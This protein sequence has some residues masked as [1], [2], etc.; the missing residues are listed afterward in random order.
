[1]GDNLTVTINGKTYRGLRGSS[2]L[3]VA[4]ANGIDIPTLC[5]EE[6][7][8]ARGSCRLCVVEVKGARKLLA[9][10]TTAVQ[11]GM[12]IETES[13]RVVEARKTVLRL[14]LANHDLRCLTCE[15]NGDCRLQDYCYRYEVEDTPYKGEQKKYPVDTSNPFFIRDYSKCI[16][17]GKCVSICK[18]INGAH[19]Y[20]FTERGF[21]SKVTSA[22]DDP[23]EN[24]TCT[25]CGM[26]VNVCP[27]GALVEKSTLWQ[28]RSW[29]MKKI[30]TT[31][32]YCGV[33]CQ[34]DL[35]VRDNR[36]VGVAKNKAEPNRGHLCIKG[37]FGWDFV[38]APDR[39]TRPL[40]RE[41]SSWQEISWEEAVRF[42]AE[43][44]ERIRSCYGP[45]SL[46]GLTSAKCTNEENYLFQKFFRSV[47]GTNNVD[48]CARL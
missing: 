32:P 35:K 47:L 3:K 27:V 42:A 6:G 19:V 12:E 46:A 4:E 14:L 43:N 18:E 30:K 48:H 31:C 26:C 37:Q 38:H 10:C 44:L 33:G 41:G 20:E 39:L 23:L 25:F 1:M 36:I 8:P 16:L 24:T 22:F 15:R 13:D 7:L 21:D 34:L 45:D 28:G 9:A 2:I 5:Y 40:R 17:C 11:D 29:E